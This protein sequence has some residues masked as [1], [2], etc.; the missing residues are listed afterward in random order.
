MKTYRSEDV[1]Q[2]SLAG[3]FIKYPK[4]GTYP[5]GIGTRT[6]HSKWKVSTG[7]EIAHPNAL[8]HSCLRIQGSESGAGDVPQCH[9]H[10]QH[11]LCLGPKNV[12]EKQGGDSRARLKNVFL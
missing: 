6:G 2:D 7:A 9:E 1:L 8:L 3:S 5:A 4:L 10:C 11:L 12:L